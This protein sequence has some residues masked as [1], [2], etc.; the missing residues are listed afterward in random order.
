MIEY[1]VWSPDRDTF[2]TTML[3]Q[4]LPG[5]QP[6]CRLPEDDEHVGDGGSLVW[7]DGIRY[8]E[9]GPVIKEPATYDDEG[10]ELTPAVM[11]AGHH[12]NLVA[13][14]PVAAL[15]GSWEGILP[16]LGLMQ[17]TPSEGGEPVALAGT[18]GVKIYRAED[19]QHRVAVWA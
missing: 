10:N 8:H 14:G 1:L 6:I 19:V 15:L 12:A 13:Y 5:D 3:A 2:I 18:S 9:I 16:L 17:E 7:I 4:R 11:V